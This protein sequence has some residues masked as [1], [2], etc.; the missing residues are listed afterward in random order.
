MNSVFPMAEEKRASSFVKKGDR[1]MFT[2]ELRPGE[3]TIVS[4]KKLLKDANKPNG[5]TSVPQYVAIAPGQPVEVEETDPSQ[6]NRFSAVI[7]KIERLYMGKDSSDDEDLLDV[8]DDDQYDTEDSFIDDAELDE[9]FE[10][11]N[12]A[13][14]H[15]GF[16]VN[17][18][19]LER[20]NEPPVLPNQQPKKRRRKDILKNAGE[21][22]DG[23]GSNKNVKVGRPAS[24]KTASLQAKNMLNSSENLVAPGE[25]IEDLKLPNQPDVSGIISKR[26]TADTKPIL[27]PSVSLKTSSDDV[28]AVTDAKDADKQKIGAFQSKNISDKY[29]DDSGSFDASHHKYNEKSAYAHSKSQAGRPL[30]NIDD[31]ENINR[32][33]EKNGMRELP[34]LNLSEGKSA[35]QATKSENMHKKEGSSVRP[36]TSMLEKALCELEKM[37]AESRPPAV[38]NQEADATSQAVK[39]RLPR[40][41][42]LKL[43]KVARLAATHGKVSKEL[44]NRL[45][46]ILGHL[47]QLRTL[48]RNLKIMINMGL[49][50]KQEEDNRFQQIKKEVVDLIKMQAPTLESKQQQKGEASG[51]FQ[52]FGPDGKPITKRKFT[53]DAAL[54]DKICD[55]YDL[56]VD[57]LDENAGPQI[58][59][60]YAELAQLW[61]S[62]YMDNHG[63]KR[64]ICRAKERRRA[65]YN[66][67]KD[68]EKI[69]RK[70][71][72]VPKQ[73]EN[74]RFD[75]NSIA[76]QQNPRERS[77]P[78]SSSHAYTSGNKQASNTSTTGRFPCPMNGLKQEKTKG[79]SSSS[80]D[81]VRAADG[82]LTKKVKRKPEL[83]LEGGHLGAEKVASLQGEERPRSLKQSIGS[84]P[85]KSNL[86]PT[87]LPDLEQSS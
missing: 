68:Q 58:R 65:L 46:S 33:K 74:V 7:E 40:E 57:G 70:K 48:K 47:I 36:K 83:E 60:L 11:D 56:F 18:G 55:L 25:H 71:L 72:L 31:L 64:G 87:S 61:P 85:T 23:H 39:R 3:T 84:L 17:R 20:I 4:W 2:V 24:A 66:K 41:I 29:K 81:D 28:P 82:V 5:S 38:D 69:K 37:V 32:T 26:K 14:K 77:A 53:M 75:I 27:N 34:D 59:K 52:E 10:V 43:A 1:Q 78:E 50:A 15:D 63:I 35:T 54:E 13:I 51:D 30:S 19:K 9:Y 21:S 45:M 22:N 76:S 86:Q 6:P 16:F 8:P 44:I 73:E 49:S 80:V 12:S 67:H 42:K 79:S 62:G